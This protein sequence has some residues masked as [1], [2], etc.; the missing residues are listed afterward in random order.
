MES[1][2]N[3]SINKYYSLKRQYNKQR[4]NLKKNII[5]NSN[6]STPEKRIKIKNIKQSCIFCG[7]KKVGTIFGKDNNILFATC[8]DTNEPCNKK[9][10]IR[11]VKRI[12]LN[13]ILPIYEEDMAEY[14]EEIINNKTKLLLD[15]D[16]T[17]NILATFDEYMNIYEDTNE[18]Y[19]RLQSKKASLEETKDAEEMDVLKTELEGYIINI[20]SIIKDYK[21]TKDTKLL[22]ESNNIYSDFI[23]PLEDRIN[24]FRFNHREIV[25]NNSEKVLKSHKHNI[26]DMEILFDV[27]DDDI[28]R[29]DI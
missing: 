17:E 22:E 16:D 15:M 8:G 13:K 14:T 9:I 29:F 26:K 28:I 11:L 27:D 10:E 24:S 5:D 20:K 23:K 25:D 2:I 21:E 19:M 4:E 1:K 7:K 12:Q 18:I 3:Q 6:L